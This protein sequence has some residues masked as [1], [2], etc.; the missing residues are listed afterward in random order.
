MKKLELHPYCTLFPACTEEELQTLTDD[1]RLNGLLDPVVLLDGKILDG[2]NRDTACTLL[3]I[4]PETIEYAGD[5]PLGFVLSKNLHR[6]QLTTSQRA[7]IASEIAN[8]RQG[9]RT[10]LEPCRNSGK[11]A[12]GDAAKQ[13]NVSRDSVQK[14]TKLRKDASPEVIQQVKEG[15]KT[16]HAA[17]AERKQKSEPKQ[18]PPSKPPRRKTVA[19]ER[20]DEPQF[21]KIPLPFDHCTAFPVFAKVFRSEEQKIRDRI[22]SEMEALA[23]AIHNLND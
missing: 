13:M 18:H 16:V 20:E 23:S 12:Q 1:I 11:V 17:L 15:K 21:L 5:D 4:K 6:R 10:D 9:E 2:R 7:M 8:I 22:I 3:G 14:A 19:Q